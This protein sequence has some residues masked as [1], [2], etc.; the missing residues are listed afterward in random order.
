MQVADKTPLKLEQAKGAVC[1]FVGARRRL[2]VMSVCAEPTSAP[3]SPSSDQSGRAPSGNWNQARRTR[4]WMGKKGVEMRWGRKDGA[5]RKGGREKS[6]SG[7]RWH[8]EQH[9]TERGELRSEWKQTKGGGNV[10]LQDEREGEATA[11]SPSLL[12]RPP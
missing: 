8:M 4:G 5:Q 6:E 12:F 10:G 11:S 3:N 1:A 7:E 2:P 9:K